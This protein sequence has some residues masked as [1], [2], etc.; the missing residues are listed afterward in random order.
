[1]ITRA[2]DERY[3]YYYFRVRNQIQYLDIGVINEPDRN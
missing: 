1:M 3:F 2:C